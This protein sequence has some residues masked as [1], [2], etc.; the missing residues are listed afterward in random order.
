MTSNR[1]YEL[2]A[3][4]RHIPTVP[5]HPMM[6]ATEIQPGLWCMS[7]GSTDPIYARVQFIRRGHE[8]GYRAERFDGELIAYYTTFRSA[9]LHAW[10]ETVGPPGGLREFNRAR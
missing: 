7:A 10:E 4:R 5:W 1:R 9:C 6:D 3:D 8:L 2:Q